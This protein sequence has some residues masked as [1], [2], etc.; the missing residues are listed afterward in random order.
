MHWSSGLAKLTQ[1]HTHTHTHTHTHA[2]THGHTVTHLRKLFGAQL[3][4]SHML[5]SSSAAG[6]HS[7][8]TGTHASKRTSAFILMLSLT[9][10]VSRWIK[11]MSEFCLI[12]VS[13]KRP[14][15]VFQK[16]TLGTF[17][18]FLLLLFFGLCFARIWQEWARFYICILSCASC[19]PFWRRAADRVEKAVCG[20]S[21]VNTVQFVGRNKM[22]F[23]VWR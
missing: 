6:L 19:L 9:C 3:F 5:S 2:G 23:S 1:E 7:S 8:N 18:S 22:Y 10:N 17:C 14:F 21:T 13:K 16:I 15:S 4:S 11:F 20:S 12:S